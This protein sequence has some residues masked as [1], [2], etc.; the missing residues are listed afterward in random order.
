MFDLRKTT[1]ARIDGST[2]PLWWGVAAI[3]SLGS[4]WMPRFLSFQTDETTRVILVESS[5]FLTGALL[6]CLRPRRVWRWAAASLVAIAGRDMVWLCSDPNLSRMSL[7]EMGSYMSANWQMYFVQV[8]PVLI[9][10]LVG[11]FISSAGLD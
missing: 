4:L 9:G 11:S 8:L 10:A 6:G 1:G 3:L 7:V 5:L 2:D